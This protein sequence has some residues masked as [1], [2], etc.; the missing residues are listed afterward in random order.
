MHKVKWMRLVMIDRIADHD[1][2][3]ANETMWSP[4]RRRIWMGSKRKQNEN[5]YTQ[6]THIY[7]DEVVRPSREFIYFVVKLL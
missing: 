5:R 3:V 4:R 1:V 7:K 6:A 2:R